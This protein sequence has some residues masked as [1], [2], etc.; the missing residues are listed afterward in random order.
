LAF[1]YLQSTNINQ[2]DAAS[3]EAFD[4][5][6]PTSGYT[7]SHHLISTHHVISTMGLI[8]MCLIAH[9]VHRGHPDAPHHN[10]P[11]HGLGRRIIRLTA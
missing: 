10:G 5:I 6:K 9:V 8:S 3:V 2:H 7:A 11:S 4:N 1:A